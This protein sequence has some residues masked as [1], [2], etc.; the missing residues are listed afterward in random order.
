MKHVIGADD[1]GADSLH[2][3]ELT[4]GDLLESGG[5]E[6]VVHTVHRIAHGLGVAHV[7]DEEANLG[8]KFRTTLLQAMAHIILLLLVARE[9]ANLL[10]LGVDEVLEH[11][12][13]EAA[14]AARNH[15]G[16][17]CE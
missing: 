14:R 16:L 5:M 17:T 7:T 1:V 2:R 13:A 8:G 10:K 12:V 6:D 4:R 9:D 15:E 11:G 3:E